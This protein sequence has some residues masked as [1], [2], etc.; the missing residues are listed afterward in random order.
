MPRNI[1]IILAGGVGSRLGL[2]MPKQFLNVA[3][4]TVLEHTVDAFERNAHI[5][6]I[7]IVS[8]PDFVSHVEQ[9][10]RRNPWPKVRT[11]LRGGK[12]RYDSSLSALRAF[13]SGEEVNLVFHDAVRPLVS[14]RIIDDVC[15]ALTSHEA[16]DVTVPAV[17]TIVEAANGRIVAMPDR[18][19]LRRVQTP[20]GFRLSVITE[21]YRRALADP[22]FRATDDCGV[23]FRY[24]PEVPIHLVEGEESNVKLTY[25]EDTILLERLLRQREEQ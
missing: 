4:R 7:A 1:A 20:Q 2:N 22:N 25:R 15:E 24:M 6:E 16:V 13:E 11:V 17:D 10:V 3:G 14:Q 12:E 19:R 9:I 23:V 18:S 8:N 5:H 21:A